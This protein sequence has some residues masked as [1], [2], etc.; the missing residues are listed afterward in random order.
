MKPKI[1]TLIIENSDLMRNL[2]VR[3][4]AQSPAI[5]VVGGTNDPAAAPKIIR[6]LRPDIILLE[7]QMLGEDTGA[8]LRSIMANTPTPIIVVSTPRKSGKP[9]LL[10]YANYGVVDF[11]AKPEAIIGMELALFRDQLIQKI[12]IA[13][14]PARAP[15]APVPGNA[16]VAIGSSTG[17]TEVLRSILSRL[18]AMFPPIVIVQ[19]M[20]AHFLSLLA[21]SLDAL[22]PL[23]VREAQSGDKLR[24]GCVFLAPGDFHMTI[25]K[26]QGNFQIRLEDGP[27]RW[28]CRPSIDLLF[29]SVARHGG[30][31]TVGIILTGMGHDGAEGLVKMKSAGAVTIAQDEESSAIFGMPSEA[32]K[33]GGVNKVVGLADIPEQMQRAIARSSN[34]TNQHRYSKAP[35]PAPS[36]RIS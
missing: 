12:Q 3:L 28:G 35:L 29:E 33:A 14:A 26:N 18:P 6:S 7:T 25:E 34:S 24:P 10:G 31:N 15:D 17:G 4:L 8:F 19:H 16:V 27:K 20:S 2:Y 13:A 22:S 36:E 1:R 32:I 21:N 23:T 9:S 11:L 5:E 30:K